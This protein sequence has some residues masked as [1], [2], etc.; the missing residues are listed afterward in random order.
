MITV[1]GAITAADYAEAL[2]LSI[3]PR[4]FFAAIGLALLLAAGWAL[5]E[6]IRKAASGD[7]VIPAILLIGSLLWP[8]GWYWLGISWRAKKIYGQQKAMK[9]VFELIV[10]ESGFQWSSAHGNSN[11]DWSYFRKWAEGESMFL[12]Y[13]SDALM[14][15]LPKRHFVEPN[16]IAEFRSLLEKHLP[17]AANSPA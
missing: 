13:Q 16:A 10:S 17:K 15:I 8:I 2:R 5:F 14:D 7:P 12:L 11:C 4:P 1:R 9:E 3:R 6:T